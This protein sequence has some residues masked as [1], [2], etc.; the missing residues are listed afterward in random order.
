MEREQEKSFVPP[1]HWLGPEE[2]EQG[3]WQDAARQEQRG[4][5]FHEKPVEWLETVDRLDTQ[6]VARRDFLTVMGAS[7]AMAAVSCVRRPVHKIIP[8][9][10]QPEEVTPGIPTWYASTCLECSSGCGVLVKTLEGRPI[11]LEGNPDHPINRG[12][13]CARGQ[14]SLL[15]LYDPDRLKVPRIHLRAAQGQP[16]DVTWDVMDAAIQNELKKVASK[17]SPLFLISEKIQSPTTL[18]LVDDFLSALPGSQHI[19]LESIG[20]E[21]LAAAQGILFGRE[22]CPLYRFDRADLVL[23]FGADFLGTWVSPVEFAQDW[24]EQRKLFR[25]RDV[26]QVQMSELICFESHFS[27]TGA[28]AD[29]RHLI[30]PGDELKIVLSLIHALTSEKDLNSA[31][32]PILEKYAIARIAPQVGLEPRLLNELVLKL[33]KNRGR[34]LILAGGPTVQTLEALLLQQAVGLL[35]VLLDNEGKTVGVHR[36]GKGVRAARGGFGALCSFLEAAQNGKVGAV[37]FYRS[38]PAYTFP[39]T[40]WK[41]VLKKIPLVISIQD[42]E[43]ETARLADYVLPDLH[44][45]ENWGDAQVRPGVVSLQQPALAPLYQGRSFQDS[46]LKWSNSI[47]LRVAT[48]VTLVTDWHDYLKKTWEVREY[49][50]AL[51]PTFQRFWEECLRRGLGSGGQADSKDLQKRVLQPGIL[52]RLLK[53]LEGSQAKF[54]PEVSLVLYQKVSLFDGKSANN[55]WLQELP[56]P[57]SSVTWDNYLNVSPAFAAQKHWKENEVVRIQGLEGQTSLELPVHIQPGLHPQVV[58]IALGYGR[59][60]AGKVAMGAGAN[61]YALAVRHAARMIYAGQGVQLQKTGRIQ[62]LANTQWHTATEQRPILND[63]SFET[64]RKN[65]GAVM[66]TDPHLK[67]KAVPTLWP[68]HTYTGHRWGMSIDL[69]S[70]IGCGACM[71]ACQAEN[72]VPVVGREQVK[73][74]RQMHWIRITRYYSGSPQAPAV[75]FQ[76]MLC[77]HCEN[78]PC[79]TVCPVLATVHNDE[80]LNVQ[81]YNRCVGTRYC[82]NNCPYKVRRFNFF[83]HWKNYEPPLEQAWN[84]DV[85]VRTRGIMEKCTFC[86][87]RIRSAKDQAKDEK[88]PLREG[89]IQTACQQTCPTQAIRFGD[90]NDKKSQL[91][92]EQRHPGAFHMLEVLNTKPVISYLAKVRHTTEG[93]HEHG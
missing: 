11:K 17:K 44:Y 48:R 26:S 7:M 86:T 81:I 46:L 79:E 37:I 16:Q 30:R 3:Y 55:P 71:I 33:Q 49:R 93:G 35:N 68:E 92:F 53:T 67:M 65:P 13:L 23:S 90:I 5:E 52:E 10:I 24:I 12:R 22:E 88:R 14:A 50:V 19:E 60:S 66:H 57:I 18:Q 20:T 43:D 29:Q 83:D 61:A 32:L 62:V 91:S 73:K 82:Q 41:E 77:Q 8:H 2:L 85:T 76:P 72:N 74:S 28:N 56:D 58:S 78:A 40:P 38:N 39:E 31:F 51:A 80:G 75:V 89:E 4:Q 6:G 87:Q 27:L 70:C 59:Q 21:D 69:T 36:S 54:Y 64:F 84:P 9:V 34:S 47:G 25:S 1:R 63:L 15:N 45:L 42:R